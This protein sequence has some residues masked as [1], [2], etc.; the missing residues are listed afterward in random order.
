M[1]DFVVRRKRKKKALLS[2][3]CGPFEQPD[4]AVQEKNR[5]LM[6]C[7]VMSITTTTLLAILLRT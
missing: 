3:L 6:C 5:L 4:C 2:F 7:C 1:T